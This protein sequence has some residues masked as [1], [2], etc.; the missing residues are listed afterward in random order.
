MEAF[1]SRIKILMAH[2]TRQTLL[3]KKITD[4]QFAMGHLASG[5]SGKDAHFITWFDGRLG[6]L[7]KP[8]I[9]VIYEHV[10]ESAN[11]ILLIADAFFQTRVT[12][13]QVVDYVSDR[14][15]FD[16]NNFLVL[17]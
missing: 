2:T 9:F 11:V 8:N 17:G 4:S 13:F 7:K 16:L 12:L 10:Y 14:R 5:N 1:G 3:I 6:V 15:A